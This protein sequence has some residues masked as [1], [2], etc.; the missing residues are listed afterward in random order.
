MWSSCI[1]PSSV[2]LPAQN[3]E[4]MRCCSSVQAARSFMLSWSALVKKVRSMTITPFSQA[5]WAA[6]YLLLFREQQSLLRFLSFY[7]FPEFASLPFTISPSPPKIVVVSFRCAH[8]ITRIVIA[9]KHIQPRHVRN[10]QKSYQNYNNGKQA[11]YHPLDKAPLV[12]LWAFL[13]DY[14]DWETDCR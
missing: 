9:L 3:S 2:I 12:A 5:F 4:N 13:H 6:R 7:P 11:F 1:I 8:F 14:R 10:K